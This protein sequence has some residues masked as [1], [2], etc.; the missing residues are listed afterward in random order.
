MFRKEDRPIHAFE[1]DI[2]SHP[3][4]KNIEDVNTKIKQYEQQHGKIENFLDNPFWRDLSAL[5]GQSPKYDKREIVGMVKSGKHNNNLNTYQSI[6]GDC[7]LLTKTKAVKKYMI[8]TDKEMYDYFLNRCKGILDEII[9]V[10]L[11]TDKHR[12]LLLLKNP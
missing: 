1:F 4:R 10:H 5:Y 6:L 9:L 7:F 11:D 12:Q 3:R 8:L 2:V